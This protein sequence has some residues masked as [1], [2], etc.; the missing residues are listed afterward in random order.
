MLLFV[1]IFLKPVHQYEKLFM[2]IGW[3]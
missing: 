3:K 1:P 2:K